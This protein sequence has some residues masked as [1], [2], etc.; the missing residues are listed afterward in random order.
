MFSHSAIPDSQVSTEATSGWRYIFGFSRL[1][2]SVTVVPIR[3][4]AL[5]GRM[6]MSAGDRSIVAVKA[7]RMPVTSPTCARISTPE[8]ASASTAA[9]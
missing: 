5:G 6:T 7:L 9:R 1:G 3:L 4:S 2:S 8:K